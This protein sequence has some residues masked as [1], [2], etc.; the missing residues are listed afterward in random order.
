MDGVRERATA[1]DAMQMLPT[2]SER[3]ISTSLPR[4][5]CNELDHYSRTERS[6]DVSSPIFTRYSSSSLRTRPL[7]VEGDA[8]FFAAHR[9][10]KVDSISSGRRPF[11]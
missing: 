5:F 3:N 10:T 7:Q 4:L 8:T 6:P 1:Y 11:Q 9:E 2:W